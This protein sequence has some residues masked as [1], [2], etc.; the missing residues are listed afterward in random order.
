MAQVNE[1]TTV[2]GLA[3]A[4]LRA[5]YELMWVKQACALI[6]LKVTSTIRKWKTNDYENQEHDGIPKVT[7]GV[8]QQK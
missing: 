4:H 1:N 8:I 5:I 2:D 6:M 7:D 3:D